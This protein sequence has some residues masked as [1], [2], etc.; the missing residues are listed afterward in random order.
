M[1]MNLLNTGF[2]AA[3]YK[4]VLKILEKRMSDADEKIDNKIEE[5][6]RFSR[7]TESEL[8]EGTVRP[9]HILQGSQGERGRAGQTVTGSAGK[10]GLPGDRGMRGMRGMRGKGGTDGVNPD[11]TPFVEEL[12]MTLEKSVTGTLIEVAD[13]KINQKVNIHADKIQK[14]VDDNYKITEKMIER[15]IGLLNKNVRAELGGLKIQISDMISA[16]HAGGGGTS[17]GG[18]VNILQMDDVQF[19]KR[20]QVEG[21]SILIFDA[22]KK[23]FVSE[24]LGSILLRLKVDLEVQYNKLVDVDGQYIYVGEAL[25]G[26]NPADPVWRV[27]RIEEF[28]DGDINILWSTGSAEFTQVWDDRFTFNYS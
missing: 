6:A 23:K 21:N 28:E 25:P 17:G 27:K 18:S 5:I 22:E 14:T 15:K 16:G 20:H 12:R 19:L 8:Q 4:K 2:T 1:D 7:I 24:S 11:V 3:L 10:R 9:I 26:S 13:D